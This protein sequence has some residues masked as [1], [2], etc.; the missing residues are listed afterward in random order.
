MPFETNLDK[1]LEYMFSF[2]N[3]FSSAVI[4]FIAFFE[5]LLLYQS[6]TFG[7]IIFASIAIGIANSKARIDNTNPKIVRFKINYP[8]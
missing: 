2:N 1:L 4:R 8:Q 3:C 5:D 7:V 6:V